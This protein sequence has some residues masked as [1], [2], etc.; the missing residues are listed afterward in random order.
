MGDA[1]SLLGRVE[2]KG[3]RPFPPALAV[4]DENVLDVGPLL[5]EPARLG[6]ELDPEH[7]LVPPLA[8]RR[9]TS[10]NVEVAAA[11]RHLHVLRK[12]PERP[13]EQL[14]PPPF[15]HRGVDGVHPCG[16][17]L[18]EFE[19]VAERAHGLGGLPAVDHE[20]VPGDVRARR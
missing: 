2:S 8:G 13:L 16:R 12:P 3:G 6:P 15:G 20:R 4:D 14:R 10:T 5:P 1:A 11:G 19:Q 9:A 7:V 18:H 17:P